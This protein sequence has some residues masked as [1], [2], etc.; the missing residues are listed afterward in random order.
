M[1]CF[2][3]MKTLDAWFET[4]VPQSWVL[5]NILTQWSSRGR[6]WTGLRMLV[7]WGEL[8]PQVRVQVPPQGCCFS[9]ELLPIRSSLLPLPP[10]P[11]W[12]TRAQWPLM[13]QPQVLCGPKSQNW[14]LLYLPGVCENRLQMGKTLSHSPTTGKHNRPWIFQMSKNK[15]KNISKD[16]PQNPASIT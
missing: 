15:E 4:C 3:I 14:R 1:Y 16:N 2:S 11:A 13:P 9:L 7:W 8:P 5:C 10:S 12:G 6:R